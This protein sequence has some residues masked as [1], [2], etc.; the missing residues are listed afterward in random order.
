MVKFWIGHV[1]SLGRLEGL[2]LNR[3]CRFLVY[4]HTVNFLAKTYIIFI[5]N[6]NTDAELVDSKEVGVEAHAEKT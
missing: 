4:A 5:P 1:E 6:A 2:R 3:T